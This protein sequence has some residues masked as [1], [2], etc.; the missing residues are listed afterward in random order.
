MP[1]ENYNCKCHRQLGDD[2]YTLPLDQCLYGKCTSNIDREK[3]YQEPLIL[4]PYILLIAASSVFG[5]A[6]WYHLDNW[7]FS[8]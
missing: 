3:E 8:G 6:M 7:S 2:F 5:L 4:W 1:D